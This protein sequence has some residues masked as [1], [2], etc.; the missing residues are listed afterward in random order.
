MGESERELGKNIEEST[1]NPYLHISIL[2]GEHFIFCH[3]Y[4]NEAGCVSL[5]LH[6]VLRKLLLLLFV[7]ASSSVL[8][9][10]K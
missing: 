8:S 2:E 1:D 5:N 9:K 3:D 6:F 7:Y 4:V 10:G